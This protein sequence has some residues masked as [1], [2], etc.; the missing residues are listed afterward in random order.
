MR[1]LI[2][3][4][5]KSLA[6]ALA[7]IL[8]REYC[9]TDVVHDGRSGLEYACTGSYDVIIFDVM[10][11]ALDGMTAVAELRK[12]GVD[13]PVLMLTARDRIPDKIEGLDAGSDAYLTKPFD[14]GEL[15][16]RLRALT[17]RQSKPDIHSVRAGD[18]MLSSSTHSLSCAGEDIQL[19]HKEFEMADVL[20]SNCGNTI[21]KDTLIQKV[22][23]APDAANGSNVEA[24]IS[25]LRRKLR[26]LGSRM[27]IRALRSVGYRLEEMPTE[28]E[29]PC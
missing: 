3:E 18:L 21:P 5:D 7:H 29:A 10:L 22:W 15:L 2:V 13:T 6:A 27:Q 28:G 1:A 9:Q 4:D 19:S 25:M 12:R 17:R 11:P 23:G 20:M 24:Y 26:F 8:R 14:T 16:A